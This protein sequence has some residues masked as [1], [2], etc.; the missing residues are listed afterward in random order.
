MSLELG[1]WQRETAEALLRDGDDDY[2]VHRNNVRGGLVETLAA[3]F[4]VTRRIVGAKAFAGIADAFVRA[5][6]PQAPQLSA[7]GA[8]FAA[9]IT[10]HEIGRQLPYLA[11]VA[12]LEGARAESYFAA[13]APALTPARLAALSPEEMAAAVLE[14]HPAARLVE[15]RFPIHRIWNVNQMEDV[16][17]VDMGIAETVLVTRPGMAIAMRKISLADAALVKAAGRTLG[18]AADAALKVDPGF[19]LQAALAAHFTGATF[20]D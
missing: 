8:G 3:A 19:D 20:R 10:G 15:S 7:Y 14:L 16:P 9:F 12:R 5:A 11:D 13:D 2:A 1:Q 6:P 4:P 17:A 18:E